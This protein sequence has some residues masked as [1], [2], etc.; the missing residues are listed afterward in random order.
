MPRLYFDVDED[1]EMRRD[2]DGTDLDDVGAAR[3]EAVQ[4]LV[5]L[6]MDEL[7]RNGKHKTITVVVRSADDRRLFK[8]ALSYSE[9]AD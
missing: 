3:D 5:R 7:P 6:A 1:G 4:M 8:A 2:R 9:A